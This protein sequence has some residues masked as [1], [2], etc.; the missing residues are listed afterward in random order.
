MVTTSLSNAPVGRLM[1]I[2][3]LQLAPDVCYRLRELGFCENALV[4]CMVNT[5]GNLIC[6]ICRCRVGLNEKI[7]QDILVAPFQ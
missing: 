1:R 3:K 4:R 2:H 6:E 7:A 5:E